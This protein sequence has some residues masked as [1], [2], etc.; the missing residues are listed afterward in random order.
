MPTPRSRAEKPPPEP[1]SGPADWNAPSRGLFEAPPVAPAGQ[2]AGRANGNGGGGWLSNLLTRAS[3]EGDDAS[4]NDDRGGAKTGR[5]AAAKERVPP[6]NDRNL[7]LGVDSVDSLSVDIARMI[8]HEVAA[9]LWERRNRGERHVSWRRLYTPQ[10][11]KAFEEMRKRYKSDREFREAA[12]RYIGEF[13]RLLGEVGHG[14]SGQ[15]IARNYITSE[16]GKVYTMLAHAAGR[17]E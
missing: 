9:D 12:D 7:Q 4:Q 13:D 16:A 17:L 1:P 10:G 5:P 15:V 3:R 6:A 14:D 11:R 8:D 2:D